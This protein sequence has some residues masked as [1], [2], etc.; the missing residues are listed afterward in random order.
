M[1]LENRLEIWQGWG[2]PENLGQGGGYYDQSKGGN[3]GY[4]PYDKPGY[5]ETSYDKPT[6]GPGPTYKEPLGIEDKLYERVNDVTRQLKFAGEALDAVDARMSLI[7]KFVDELTLVI[8]PAIKRRNEEQNNEISKLNVHLDNLMDDL[9]DLENAIDWL[10]RQNTGSSD[11]IEDLENQYASVKLVLLNEFELFYDK[12]EVVAGKLDGSVTLKANDRKAEYV[13]QS[14]FDQ[15]P[16]VIYSITGLEGNLDVIKDNPYSKKPSY[17]SSYDEPNAGGVLVLGYATK[18]SV[19]FEGY[20]L[21]FGD[22]AAFT[23][24]VDFQR[25]RA[26]CKAP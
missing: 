17:V 24:D 26:A 4:V 10:E 23:V 13:F 5:S 18:R 14:D 1:G 8:F 12:V 11:D 22:T 6:Y 20:D 19:T 16:G 15:V 21:S 9:A 25:V 3:D 2:I 7:K